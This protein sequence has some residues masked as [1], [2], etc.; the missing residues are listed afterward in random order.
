[1]NLSANSMLEGKYGYEKMHEIYGKVGFECNDYS[2]ERLK[3]DEDVLNS[4][5][6]RTEAENIRKSAE[7]NGLTVNQIHAPF[8]W[9]NKLWLDDS[10][11]EE[12]IFPRIVRSLEIAGIFGVTV[13]FLI[14]N[15]ELRGNETVYSEAELSRREQVCVNAL[16]CLPDKLGD[17]IAD[18]LS[19]MTDE[20]IK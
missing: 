19:E 11:F 17:K 16:S 6:F 5:S 15:S 10:F 12:T 13:D 4:E 8:S 18:L 7:R 3:N 9:S 20:F 1:M 14:G 2:L